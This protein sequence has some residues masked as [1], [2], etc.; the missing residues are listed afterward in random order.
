VSQERLSMLKTHLS[1]IEKALVEER[2]EREEM[3]E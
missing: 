3:E 1:S 2:G